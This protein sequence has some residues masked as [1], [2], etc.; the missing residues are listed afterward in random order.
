MDNFIKMSSDSEV[1]ENISDQR[2]EQSEQEENGGETQ[3][4]KNEAPATWED[5]VCFI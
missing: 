1:D 2:S 3:A 4:T 5:L